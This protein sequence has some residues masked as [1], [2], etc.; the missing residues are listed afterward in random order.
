MLNIALIGAGRIGKMHARNIVDHPQCNLTYVYDI[1]LDFATEVAK[2][3]NAKIAKK[4]LFRHEIVVFWRI[5]HPSFRS[6]LTGTT[7]LG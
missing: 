6:E 5:S 1:N 4:D 7:V 3:S 2:F